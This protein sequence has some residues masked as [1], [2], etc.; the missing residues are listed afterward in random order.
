MSR[1]GEEVHLKVQPVAF[2]REI[3]LFAMRRGEA[4]LR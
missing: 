1:R 3:G 4:F 2:Q